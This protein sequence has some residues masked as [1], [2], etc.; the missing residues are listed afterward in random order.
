[1]DF[2]PLGSSVHGVLQARILEWV[3]MPSSR[4]LLNPGIEPASPA[5]QAD[6]LPA[7]PSRK[8]LTHSSA[9]Y[10]LTD[11]LFCC[12]DKMPYSWKNSSDGN[13]VCWRQACCSN[14][15]GL[16]GFGFSPVPSV[17]LASTETCLASS[18]RAVSGLSVGFIVVKFIKLLYKG[19]TSSYN[20]TLRN[21]FHRGDDVHWHGQHVLFL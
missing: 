4:N 19:T 17:N 14:T 5:L 15:G 9:L 3:A 21:S 1:M 6:S 2:S 12:V 11:R 7:E 20:C 16:P 10:I 13:S 18:L 8:P